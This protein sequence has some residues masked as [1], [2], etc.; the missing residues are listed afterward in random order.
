MPLIFYAKA[1]PNL[2]IILRL[3]YFGFIYFLP[4]LSWTTELS[5][6]SLFT[7]F[8][9]IWS[10]GEILSAFNRHSVAVRAITIL[11]SLNY[12][13]PSYTKREILFC[14]FCFINSREHSI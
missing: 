14:L 7:N 3:F 8:E 1:T 9:E 2:A 11:C 13:Y 4:Q 12:T 6:N 10:G 5:L